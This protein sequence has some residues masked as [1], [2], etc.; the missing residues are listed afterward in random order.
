MM[1]SLY[2]TLGICLL[3]AAR[4][5]SANRSWIA[6]TPG[7]VLL[8]PLLWRCKHPKNGFN[9]KNSWAWLCLLCWCSPACA[10]A[11][12]IIE[13]TGIG[14]QCVAL[15][16][17]TI[18]GPVAN[19]FLKQAGEPGK[20]THDSSL[21]RGTPRGEA[22]GLIVLHRYLFAMKTVPLLV[23]EATPATSWFVTPSDSR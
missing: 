19:C 3:L 4:N 14:C 17:Q 5:P 16:W 7:R 13:Q 6:F 10:R 11:R 20:L 23:P 21:C 22:Q 12:K 9:T 2:V 15:S 8:T 1:L 18:I